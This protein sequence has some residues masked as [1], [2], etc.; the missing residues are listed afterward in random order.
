ME[1]LIRW[2]RVQIV[3]LLRW[4]AVAMFFLMVSTLWPYNLYAQSKTSEVESGE[5]RETRFSVE[6]LNIQEKGIEA[7]RVKQRS[8]EVEKV[9][10][11]CRAGPSELPLKCRQS[12]E[13]GPTFSCNP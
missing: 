13:G 11:R 9:D 8:K 10:V 3:K 2:R 5:Q 6:R 12:L 7:T 1:K 4:V